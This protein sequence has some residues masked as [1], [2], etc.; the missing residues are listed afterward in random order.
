MHTL[1]E[2]QLAGIAGAL[3]APDRA[4]RLACLIEDVMI[5]PSAQELP[6][7][8]LSALPWLAR[9]DRVGGVADLRAA[10][11][12]CNAAVDPA[13]LHRV[14]IVGAAGE[15]Q[16]LAVLCRDRGIAVT[17]IIDD[18]PAKAGLIVAGIKVSS[19]AAL[20]TLDRDIPVV[21]ASHRVLRASERL[22]QL[23]Y[24]AFA[25]F[26]VLQVLDPTAFPPHMFYDG[27]LEDLWQNRD[28]Y[29][30]FDKLLADDMSRQ[31]L[32]AVLGFRQTLD[33]F[34]LEPVI[35]W[36]L[37][38]PAGLL[39]YGDDEVYVDGGSFDGDTIRLFINRVAGRFSR[40]IA[41]EP[42]PRTFARL[43]ANFAT[44]Q[45]IEP[46]NA[47]LYRQK[48]RLR[49]TD[50]ASR[51]ALITA[52]GTHEI[53]AVSLDEV[54]GGNRVSYIK[55][56]IEGA[57]IDALHGARH[58]IRRWAPKLA[59]SAYHRP[60]DL[61]QIADVVREIRSDYRLYLRQ[62]DGGVIETVLYA[63]PAENGGQ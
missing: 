63:L 55:M 27:W 36:E 56:N 41:F 16:R 25:P 26:A 23:G 12:R 50:D 44:E 2:G 30:R 20:E 34:L 54:L 21:I 6:S 45:R 32:D 39:Q 58:A 40:V 13:A 43:K 37:Y 24:R 18:D 4:V 9:L 46:I 38:G 48:A 62:H 28:R 33:P 47:G 17:A 52:D 61:W 3:A 60:T 10:L 57:E 35:E 49:F 11:R 7:R 59:I 15:G 14:I 5:Q 19:S 8:R 51:G 42:D 31:V 53:E 29:A 1:R 22:K